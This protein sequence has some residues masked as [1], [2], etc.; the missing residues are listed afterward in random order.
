VVACIVS[1]TVVF[2]LAFF[3]FR[4]RCLWYWS[5]SSERKKLLSSH[6][7]SANY[8]NDLKNS[9]RDKPLQFP[10]SETY[11]FQ[12]PPN[13]I[14]PVNIE[15]RNDNS[16]LVENLYFYVGNMF[17]SFKEALYTRLA[18]FSANFCSMLLI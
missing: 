16:F 7:F 3:S 12:I 13:G 11:V 18:R 14:I 10:K 2:I 6:Y 5:L 9:C 4:Y 15:V 1:Y 17:L 8:W